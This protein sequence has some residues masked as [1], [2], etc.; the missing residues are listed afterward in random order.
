MMEPLKPNYGS[1]GVSPMTTKEGYF[2][3][4]EK[5]HGYKRGDGS[6]LL[7]RWKDG[8]LSHVEQTDPIR[9]VKRLPYKTATVFTQSDDTPHLLTVPF[10]ARERNVGDRGWKPL[11]FTH[12][13]IGSTHGYYS[14]VQHGGVERDIAAPGSPHWMPQLLPDWYQYRPQSSEPRTQAGLIGE[15]PLLMALAAFSTP[16]TLNALNAL[17]TSVVPGAWNPHQYQYPSGREPPSLLRTTMMLTV[18][19]CAPKGYRCH[20]VP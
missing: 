20:C 13:R 17:L 5:K 8:R 10:D 4:P 18:I 12:E 9:K 2:L 11:G 1:D 6:A 14:F 19:R 16:P 3:P 7:L 15:L